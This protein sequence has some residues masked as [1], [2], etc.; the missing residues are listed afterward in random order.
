MIHGEGPFDYPANR[1][2][3]QKVPTS[4][5]FIFVASVLFARGLLLR[6]QLGSLGVGRQGI[7]CTAKRSQQAGTRPVHLGHVVL[8][9]DGLV[10]A[11]KRFLQLAEF[12]QYER[13]AKI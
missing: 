9:F 12:S 1:S 6:L 2:S 10:D 3:P 7:V 8:D 13:A 5:T 4:R 11:G